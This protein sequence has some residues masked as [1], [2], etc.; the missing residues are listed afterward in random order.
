LPQGFPWNKSR[1]NHDLR[2]YFQR[3]IALRKAHP[4]L[5]RGSFAVLLSKNDVYAFARQGEGET[6][7]VALNLSRETQDV[8]LPVKGRSKAKTMFQDV[9]R[10]ASDEY[11]LVRGKLHDLKLA[12]RSGLVLANVRA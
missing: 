12:P 1:W 6:V 10:T 7:I 11:P 2:A 9:W 5:R 8:S 3:C 4:A